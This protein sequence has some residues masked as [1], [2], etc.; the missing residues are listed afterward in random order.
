[1]ICG[2]ASRSSGGKSAPAPSLA[3]LPGPP[4]LGVQR[5]EWWVEG[6]A[7][8]Y[9]LA[10][11]KPSHSLFLH[12]PQ[13]SSNPSITSPHALFASLSLNRRSQSPRSM[14]SRPSAVRSVSRFHSYNCSFEFRNRRAAL[15]VVWRD[16]CN[17]SL[18]L[19]RC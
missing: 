8:D 14:N 7:Q 1:M 15:V 12:K 4:T 2:H 11:P 19:E 18:T 5:I 10:T 13:A 3:H 6:S 17:V 9:A 16:M